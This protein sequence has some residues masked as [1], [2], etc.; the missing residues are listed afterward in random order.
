MPDQVLSPDE[1]EHNPEL[2]VLAI[3]EQVLGTADCALRSAHPNLDDSER[4]YWL[5]RSFSE[6]VAVY[7]LSLGSSLSHFIR[8]YRAAILVDQ[9]R[10]IQKPPAP[11]GPEEF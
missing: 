1:L 7:I 10:A 6:E 11:A 5:R 4:P 9:T 2:A 3:L 8:N